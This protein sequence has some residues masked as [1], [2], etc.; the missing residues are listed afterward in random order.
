MI[1]T[2]GRSRLLQLAIPLVRSHGFTRET[3]ARSVLSLPK[4]HAK[5]LSDTADDDARRTLLNAWLEDARR[6]MRE[7]VSSEPPH[8]RHV[9]RSRLAMN[10]P[11]LDHLP[12]AFALLA[13]SSSVLPVDPTPIMKHAAYVAD[14]ACWIVDPSA[15]EMSWYTRRASLSTIYLAAELHQFTSPKTVDSFLDY[16]LDNRDTTERAVHEVALYG[17]YIFKSWKG[18]LR[19]SGRL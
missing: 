16:L 19:S 10:E 9:L 1:T 8:V 2:T 12:E 18:I 13:T 5:P 3:L 14:D 7:E 6:R 11:V 4:P 17:E 15:K